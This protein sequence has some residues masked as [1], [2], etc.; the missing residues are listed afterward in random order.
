MVRSRPRHF[1]AAVASLTASL[2]AIPMGF[3]TAS[4]AL[5]TPAPSVVIG[6]PSGDG[7]TDGVVST[8]SAVHVPITVAGFSGA[9]QLDVKISTPVG[10]GYFSV[11][12]GATS[13]SANFGY[14]DATEVTE[15]AFS[16]S[17]ADVT[18]VLANGVTWVA[19]ISTAGDITVS[20]AES[21]SGV[22]YNHANGHYYKPVNQSNVSWNSAKNASAATSLFGLT[23]YLATVTTRQENDFITYNVSG[24]G[25]WL[26]GSD[27]G[28]SGVWRW[29]TGPENGTQFWQG[30]GG[31]STR[32]GLFAGWDLG[33]PD[34]EYHIWGCGFLCLDNE[35][36]DYVVTNFNGRVGEWV[37]LIN[38]PTNVAFNNDHV[39]WYL[40]EYGGMDGET[41]TG[42]VV[43]TT[44]SISASDPIRIGQVVEGQFVEGLVNAD[45]SGTNPVDFAVDLQRFDTISSTDLAVTLTLPSSAGTLTALETTGL[46][47]EEGYTDFSNE[48][49]LGFYGSKA[50]VEAALL[51][52]SWTPPSQFGS[53]DLEVS[54]SEKEAGMFYNP[55]NQHYYEVKTWGGNT[56]IST[57]NAYANAQEYAGMEGYLVTITTEAENDFIAQH[58]TASNA[59]IGATDDTGLV[60][61]VAEQ[62]YSDREGDWHWFTGPEAGT[63]FWNGGSGG[64]TR[65][66][67]FENWA[68]GEPN[69]EPRNLF[70]SDGEDFAVTNFNGALGYWNDALND[71]GGVNAAIIEY[72][73]I[74]GEANKA[75]AAIDTEEMWHA[76][77]PDAPS[78]INVDEGDESVTGNFVDATGNGAQIIGREYSIDGGSTWSELELNAGAFEIT[79]LTNGQ[80]Y[81]LCFRTENFVGYSASSPCISVIP[82]TV[83]DAPTL[84]DIRPRD[85]GLRV[86]VTAGEFNG[87]HEIESWEYALD[88]GSWTE[89]A[90]D[91]TFDGFLRIESGLANGVEVSVCV[92]AVNDQGASES[93]N[94]L[95]VTPDGPSVPAAPEIA[96]VIVD[97]GT[98][99]VTVEE[100]TNDGGADIVLYEYSLDDGAS[101]VEAPLTPEPQFM[102][103]GGLHRPEAIV[104]A[105]THQWVIDGL[106]PGSS[107]WLRFRITNDA[108][109]SAVSDR[110]LI[111]VPGGELAATGFTSDL[112]LPA[113]LLLVAAGVAIGLRRRKTA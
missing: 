75:K 57:A 60:N 102:M 108:G 95:V 6:T 48:T 12:A 103:I 72:G 18:T 50:N 69:N 110:Y 52:L 45:W 16:G 33:E 93:S 86:T 42:R 65:N 19:P 31:G 96:A 73:G 70:D 4:P 15:Y 100:P 34:D 101:W 79:G 62:R 10:E 81:S 20:V 35:N 85:E 58:T 21:S 84:A 59:W 14:D 38:Q 105:T 67:L 97:E 104:V 109:Y 82:A 44:A 11:N 46:A 23:G 66:G 98:V 26:G 24:D 111:E 53:F 88:G 55:D 99:T 32:N 94:C 71:A 22:F 92:R 1:R 87:G 113:G 3:V 107:Y 47:L 37:D 76:I 40:I 25:M 17:V 8:E 7:V 61:G 27:A 5:A 29:K 63:E 74:P 112:G 77:A 43:E 51:A 2:L 54:V 91:S 83:P 41:F 30:E 36:D 64:S 78:A 9:S 13:I 89:F 68:P 28:D 39:D 80:S 56:S 49:A 106:T 90:D